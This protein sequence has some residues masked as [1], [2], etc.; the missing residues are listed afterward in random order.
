[1]QQL[2][3]TGRLLSWASD[4]DQGTIDQALRTAQL[5]IIWDHVSL[6]PDAHVGIGSTVGSVVPTRGAI[7]PSCAGVDLGCGIAA[8]ETDLTED[9]LDFDGHQL[10]NAFEQVVPA[11]VG[12]G[13][14]TISDTALSWLS[15]NPATTEL[16]I[17]Q[18]QTTLE[19]FGSL[20]SGN[21]FV[22]VCLDERGVVWL[23]LHS[24]SRGIGNQLAQ[25]HISKAKLD[26]DLV[27]SLKDPDLAYFLQGT[28]EFNLYIEDMLWA[29]EY[30]LGN[31][32]TMM[33]NA[34]KAFFTVNGGG[35]EVSR[36]N[37]HHNFSRLEAHG[38]W[39]WVTRKGAISAELG[40]LGVIPGSMGTKSYVVEGL[41][42]TKSWKSCSHGAGRRMS[43]SKARKTLTTESLVEAMGDRAWQANKADQLLDEHPDSYK[44]ID[45]VMEDQK[46]LVN[47]VH[48]LRQIVNFKGT[49]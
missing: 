9:G 26:K 42:E 7:I 21:H 35:S 5:D 36:I 31:R 4:I 23:M 17:K 33:D 41:G 1:M 29:Q 49:N 10:I 16:T 37:C 43:R 34:L 44:N 12:K 15:Q 30:A 28:P 6:M 25:M 19:Q 27:E 11:G 18:E 20:G 40:E 8:V 3:K 48:T 38:T 39:I 24:G 47:V 32:E 14:L 2:D 45:K 46:D 13:H 22:E